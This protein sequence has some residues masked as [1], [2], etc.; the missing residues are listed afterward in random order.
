[1]L[2]LI[3]AGGRGFCRLPLCAASLWIAARPGGAWLCCT[4][5]GRLTR[6]FF[7]VNTVVRC[8]HASMLLGGRTS[9]AAFRGLA[10]KYIA[11]V[12]KRGHEVCRS[13]GRL[14]SRRAGENPLERDGRQARFAAPRIDARI[15][16]GTVPV[17]HSTFTARPTSI[18]RHSNT[19]LLIMLSH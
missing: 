19:T 17:S 13:P 14:S 16:P 11:I 6:L 1:M 3:G 5:H 9:T 8:M 4:A 15:T 10:T 12:I 7:W 18:P 2:L